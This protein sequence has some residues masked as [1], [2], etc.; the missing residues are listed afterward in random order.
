MLI[1]IFILVLAFI[2]FTGI[3]F[4]VGKVLNMS[5][6]NDGNLRTKLRSL[7]GLEFLNIIFLSLVLYFSFL[8]F[9]NGNNWFFIVII[10]LS[11]VLLYMLCRMLL[12]KIKFTASS[13]SLKFIM[14]VGLSM[15]WFPIFLPIT[16]LFYLIFRKKAGTIFSHNY[17][18]YLTEEQLLKIIEKDSELEAGEKDM[19]TSIVGFSNIKANEIMIPRTEVT[20][21]SIDET[22]G[23]ILK[24][25]KAKGFSRIP[26]YK[27]GLDNIIGV[28][29][30]K[31][32]IGLN[33]DAFN[34]EQLIRKAVFMPETAKLDE[35]L[36]T[37]IEKKVQIMIILDEY[38]GTSGI[39]TLE[40]IIE[41]I[42]GE[43]EDEYDKH[44]KDIEKIEKYKYKIKST[45]EIEVIAE[46]LNINLPKIEGIETI[47]GFILYYMEKIPKRG[48]T[49]EYNNIHFRI[50]DSDER[51]I[52][53]ILLTLRH[54]T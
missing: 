9:R 47:G 34:I 50:L 39:I 5:F 27:E 14:N 40:D 45:V 42:V 24:L 38:G 13:H 37:V 44:T 36:K 15:F 51:K 33:A 4:F 10:F 6:T 7:I 26:V 22:Y 18:S 28:L 20:S 48:E 25:V 12:A 3:D 43:I 23:N 8:L 54:G 29:Y 30:V 17:P 41:E 16:E 1:N 35:L 31:D 19:L 53:W 49:M 52:N 21:V 11:F 32:L 46:K 2:I